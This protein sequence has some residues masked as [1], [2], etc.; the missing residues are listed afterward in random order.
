ML[1]AAAS[2]HRWV[3]LEQ[4]CGRGNRCHSTPLL[5]LAAGVTLAALVLASIAVRG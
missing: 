1:L 5:V 3:T 4:T 2:C